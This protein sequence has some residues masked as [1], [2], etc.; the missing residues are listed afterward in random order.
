MSPKRIDSEIVALTQAALS[1]A[2]STAGDNSEMPA[3]AFAA[4]VSGVRVEMNT[5][6]DRSD[7]D[8]Q[9]LLAVARQG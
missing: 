8:M 9:T 7:A 3:E 1:V 6:V 5:M 2:R 4:R